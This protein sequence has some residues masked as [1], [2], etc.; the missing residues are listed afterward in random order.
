MESKIIQNGDEGFNSVVTYQAKKLGGKINVAASDFMSQQKESMNSFKMSEV[1]S[2]ITGLQEAERSAVEKRIEDA[3][4]VKLESIQE[5]S[6]KKA[7][8]LGLEEG[9]VEGFKKYEEEIKALLSGFEK[10]VQSFSALKSDLITQNETQIVDMIYYVANSIAMHEVE[11][12]PDRIIP[13]IR[14][15][16]R[17]A[18]SDE[19]ILIRM[20]KEDLA[21][22]NSIKETLP[23]EIEYLKDAAIEAQDDIAIGGCIIE[24]NY[25]VIDATMDQRVKKIWDTLNLKKPRITDEVK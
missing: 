8:E 9:R 7:F 10:V 3:A 14:E 4:L 15:C 22:F 16:M 17:S 1:I 12:K 24:T 6:Y 21:Y 23:K 11:Q 19:K 13:V 2:E 25:G 18:Q 20:S 5:E